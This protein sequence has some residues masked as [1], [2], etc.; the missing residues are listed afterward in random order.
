[1]GEGARRAIA[2]AAARGGLGGA[3]SLDAGR[4]SFGPRS[5]GRRGR[6]RRAR[7]PGRAAVEPG[8]RAAA[9]DRKRV[10]SGKSVSVSLDLGGRRIIK[11]KRKS[12]CK[13]TNEH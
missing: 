1:M 2:G 9:A 7:N 8:A 10:G 3:R 4:G 5:A 12:M 11:K 13:T 6:D